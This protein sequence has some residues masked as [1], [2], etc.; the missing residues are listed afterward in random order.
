[1]KKGKPQ[2]LKVSERALFARINR[3][4]DADELILRRCRPTMRDHHE[5][6]DYYTVNWRINGIWEKDIDLEAYG[7]EVGALKDY[8]ELATEDAT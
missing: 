1:M 8:E 7:R 4:I 6:G 3:K 5:L 2:K